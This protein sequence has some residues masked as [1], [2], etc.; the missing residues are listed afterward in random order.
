[1]GA[2]FVYGTDRA[3]Y[4]PAQDM[5]FMPHRRAFANSDDYCA[6]ELHEL[7][8]WTGAAHRLGRLDHVTTAEEYAREE[9]VAELGCAFLCADLRVKPSPRA[10]H[11]AYLAHWLDAMK[12]DPAYLFK[13]A[14]L[15]SR[16]AFYLA[17]GGLAVEPVQLLLPDLAA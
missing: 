4:A 17:S 12:A 6:T 8:H 16:A 10:D 14:S 3:Y 1:T 2:R 5:I 13:V 11:A 15:A 9:L 7:V